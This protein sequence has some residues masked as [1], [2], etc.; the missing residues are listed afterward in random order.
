MLKH[1]DIL[2]F[3][4]KGLR[5]LF[6]RFNPLRTAIA[7][8]LDGVDLVAMFE[9]GNIKL[10]QFKW[11]SE[12]YQYISSRPDKWVVNPWREIALRVGMKFKN[13]HIYFGEII[14]FSDFDKMKKGDILKKCIEKSWLR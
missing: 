7:L 4:A 1:G 11:F 6:S 12:N 2:H 9:N 8:K 10:V 14:G 3:K 5:R 13:E